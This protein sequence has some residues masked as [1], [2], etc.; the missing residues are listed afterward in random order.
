MT[1]GSLVNTTAGGAVTL[2][3]K[4]WTTEENRLQTTPESLGTTDRESS[5]GDAGKSRN[6]GRD[7]TSVSNGLVPE[8]KSLNLS[9]CRSRVTSDQPLALS[10]V[11][12]MINSSTSTRLLSSPSSTVT[13][14]RPKATTINWPLIGTL[15]GVLSLLAL[16]GGCCVCYH[17]LW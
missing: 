1:S 3:E 11:T 14:S 9:M 10:T 8:K 2:E 4:P 13:T 6:D 16:L 7:L 17:Y 5:V 12:V 15:I